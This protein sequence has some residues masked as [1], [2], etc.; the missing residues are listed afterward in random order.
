MSFGEH[1]EELRGVLVKAAFALGVGFLLGLGAANQVVMLIQTPLK[2]ALENYYL[3][4]A[5]QEMEESLGADILGEGLTKEKAKELREKQ[6][7]IM[8]ER[9]ESRMVP[10]TIQIDAQALLRDLQKLV[11]DGFNKPFDPP[12]SLQQFEVQTWDKVDIR[13]QTLNAHEAFMI[14]MKAGFI[15]GF[16]FASPFIFYYIWSFIAAGLYP[17]EKKYIHRY[18]PISLLLFFAGAALAFL[19]VFEPVLDFLFSFNRAMDIDPD[20]RISEWMSFVLFLPLGFG[21]AFQLPLVMLFA[22]RIGLIPV[23]V[24]VKK[25]RI[26]VVVIFILSMFLTPAD[27]ISMLLMAGPLCFLYVTGILF[28]KYMPGNKN[29]F[30]AGY[31]P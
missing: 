1:L 5:R 26:A 16:V 24:F 18:L 19:F 6:E 21:L 23:D 10:D 11:P 8:K 28:C 22:Q 12:D 4:S 2:T 14:W 9:L 29:P 27:P 3:E 25:W 31:D 15:S 17:H 7:E 13:V 30:A 20:P